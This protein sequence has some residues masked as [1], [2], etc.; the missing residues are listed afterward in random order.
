MSILKDVLF[1]LGCYV[2]LSGAV[3]MIYALVCRQETA[4]G[5]IGVGFAIGMI[6]LPILAYLAYRSG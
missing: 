4:L 2:W 5:W 3:I 1:S 6:G